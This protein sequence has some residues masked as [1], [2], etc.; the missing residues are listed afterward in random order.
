[1]ELPT[2][3]TG[4]SAWDLA[5]YFN[6]NIT[7]K[8]VL[9]LRKKLIVAQY[10]MS[11]IFIWIIVIGFGQYKG[12]ISFDLGF[13]TKNIINLKTQYDEDH[14]VNL[15]REIPEVSKISRS[16]IVTSLGTILI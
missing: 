9:G 3:I 15:L 8:G 11:L 16:L 10:T 7:T 12:F 1:M 13:K 5:E 2:R 6:R 4:R 14:L